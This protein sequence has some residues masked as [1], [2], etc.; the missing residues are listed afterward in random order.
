M[1]VLF[2]S[3]FNINQNCGGAQVS[4]ELI[5]SF[6]K[7]LG[8]DITLFD[9]Q[10]SPIELISRFDLIISSN[11][12][13]LSSQRPYIFDYIF[14]HDNH[15]R[16]EHDSCLYL[17]DDLRR[18]L[19]CHS[20]KNFFLSEFHIEFFKQKYGNYFSNVEIV[21]DP[22]DCSEV[23]NNSINKKYDIIYAGFLH[24]LKGSS[25]L[26]KFAKENPDRKIDVFGWT[27]DE[28]IINQFSS[29][30]NITFHGKKSHSEI[31]EVYTQS[32]Y[33]YH[34]PIVNE[35]FCRMVGEALLCGCDFIG[36][37]SK[38]GSIQEFEK[39][40]YNKFAEN[41]KNA[42]EIFWNKINTL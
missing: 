24:E 38:I 41:C 3:D 1:K 32:K 12:E 31:L 17:N 9:Y 40:G 18:Q 42:A 21:Y 16:L 37:K 34:N 13:A 4:N 30:K 14:N 27:Y 25:N 7:S 5:I 10:T 2:I 6:G 35:P 11:L 19:F 36:D 39:N 33:I 8:H 20:K 29:L 28:H 26:Y 23:L 22:V 15:V